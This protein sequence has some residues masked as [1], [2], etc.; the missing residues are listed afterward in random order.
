MEAEERTAPRSRTFLIQGTGSGV[1]L[2][3]DTNR[4]CQSIPAGRSC[5]V[6]SSIMWLQRLPGPPKLP[7][8]W[9]GLGRE[10]T[11]GGAEAHRQ[12]TQQVEGRRPWGQVDEREIEL[13]T[14]VCLES[15]LP[16]L[17][18]GGGTSHLKSV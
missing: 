13:Q 18:G 4:R 10:R 3:V 16:N 2:G 12:A 7:C 6:V 9:M 8:S 11:G 15:L 5:T 1:V 14:T 17:C